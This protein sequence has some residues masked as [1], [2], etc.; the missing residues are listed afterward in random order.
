MSVGGEM[1]RYESGKRRGDLK[2][3]KEIKDLIPVW[4]QTGRKIDEAIGWLHKPVD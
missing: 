3:Q 1:E 4:Y 2:L